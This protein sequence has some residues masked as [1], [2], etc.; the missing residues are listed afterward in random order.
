MLAIPSRPSDGRTFLQCLA[1]EKGGGRRSSTPSS[2]ST[3]LFWLG[4]TI[5]SCSSLLA[6]DSFS[7]ASQT[8]FSFFFLALKQ[9]HFR[10]TIF[11]LKMTEKKKK[12]KKNNLIKATRG[13]HERRSFL[14]GA[15]DDTHRSC[16]R[17]ISNAFLFPIFFS[18]VGRLFTCV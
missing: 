11:S 6:P 4:K 12:K 13:L 10:Y 1:D 14:G 5:L 15:L 17:S 8:L 18:L 7:F 16:A 2:S 9:V 3:H